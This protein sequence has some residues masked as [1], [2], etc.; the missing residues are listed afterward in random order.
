M[1]WADWN[2]WSNHPPPPPA[3][4][5]VAARK[6]T[7]DAKTMA[8]R[9][10]HKTQSVR[11]FF[12]TSIP[13]PCFRTAEWTSIYQSI[14]ASRSGSSI[15]RQ[16]EREGPKKSTLVPKRRTSNGRMIREKA[17]TGRRAGS[18]GPIRH[19]PPTTVKQQDDLDFHSNSDLE[20]RRKKMK[21][22]KDMVKK[23]VRPLA[24][25]DEWRRLARSFPSGVKATKKSATY[26]TAV[27]SSC[28]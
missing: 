10:H 9:W 23:V 18:S 14:V 20:R 21:R 7:P 24:N 5:T 17:K 27:A 11:T 3:T 1:V 12:S 8:V 22:L 26:W 19:P 4:M 6:D 2:Q 16:R 25:R 15:G 28:A 13:S